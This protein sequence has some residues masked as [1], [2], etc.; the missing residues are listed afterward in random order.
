[1]ECQLNAVKAI[2][3]NLYDIQDAPEEWSEPAEYQMN[4]G[5]ERKLILAVV[6]STLGMLTAIDDIIEEKLGQVEGYSG[7]R[8]IISVL[9]DL[10]ETLEKLHVSRRGCR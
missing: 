10:T 7:T 2:R 1:M 9:R 6:C 4:C 5:P 8:T 3:F